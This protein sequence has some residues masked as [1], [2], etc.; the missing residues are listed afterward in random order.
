MKHAVAR[1]PTS[2]CKKIKFH[3][4]L[5]GTNVSISTISRRLSKEFGLKF[6]KPA[7]KPRLTSQIKK[8]KIGVCQETYTSKTGRKCFCQTN[9]PFKNSQ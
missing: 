9:P 2:S 3:L 4:L 1:F 5:K 6:Y 8:E 7:K